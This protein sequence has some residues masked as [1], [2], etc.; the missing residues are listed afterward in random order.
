MQEYRA[1]L[2]I[3]KACGIIY[4]WALMGSFSFSRGQQLTTISDTEL[5]KKIDSRIEGYYCDALRYSG[6]I[7]DYALIQY[8]K[9]A[10]CI[11]DALISHYQQPF[12]SKNSL[13]KKINFL[14]QNHYIDEELR[15]SLDLVRE[16]ANNGAHHEQ[17]S[18][19]EFDS[20]LVISERLA[21]TRDCLV[22]SLVLANQVISGELLEEVSPAQVATENN[23]DIIVQAITSTDW[24]AHY[25]AGLCYEELI[26]SGV[27]NAE[28]VSVKESELL[29]LILSHYRSALNCYET[30]YRLSDNSLSASSEQNR[31]L[32]ELNGEADALFSYCKLILTSGVFEKEQEKAL[33]LLKMNAEN[34]H[35]KSCGLLGN[36]LYEKGDFQNSLV[37]LQRAAEQ[38]DDSGLCGLFFYYT[39]GK[40]TEP[41]FE[42][43]RKYLNLGL[44]Q[45]S[46]QCLGVLGAV[47]FNGVAVAQD[48]SKGLELAREAMSRGSLQAFQFV[49]QAES[50]MLGQFYASAVNKP[51]VGTDISVGR[52]D[53]CPCGSG[54]KYKKCCLIKM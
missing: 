41:D 51:A 26:A 37:H 20:S 1:N 49:K 24:Q 12:S 50:Q 14:T 47:Y 17:A 36:Y 6:S 2:H 9:A 4:S 31:D 13:W 19:G 30:A 53:P 39:D 7:P 40:A 15:L 18:D 45:G 48:R 3:D 34:G 33:Y 11:C 16:N 42:R 43:A 28:S 8:R 21:E 10:E 27:I 32:G 46:V 52:N 35:T 5:C 44:E 38:S 22:S 29:Q 25:R 23:S 54:K